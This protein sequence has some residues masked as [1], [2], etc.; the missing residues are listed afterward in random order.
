M[1]R[2]FVSFVTV[3]LL[4]FTLTSLNAQDCL[5]YFPDQVGA[6]REMKFFDKKD[7]M[8]SMARQ[9][10]VERT[11][12]GLDVSIRVRSTTYTADNDEM[13][14]TELTLKCEDGLFK[15]DMQDF[16]DPKT[17]SGYEGM[18]LEMTGDNLLYPARMNVGDVLPSATYTMVVKNNGITLLTTTITISERVVEAKEDVTT[19]AGTFSCYKISYK[20]HSKVGIINVHSSSVEWTAPGVGVVKTESYD[21]KGKLTG[22][23]ELSGYRQ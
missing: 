9:E 20:S 12:N 1:K 6:M 19:D 23:S 13:N 17:M 7:K 18:G 14:S 21:K 5:L 4:A 15:F 22:Y 10:V 11:V 2:T 8:T 16:L 3:V